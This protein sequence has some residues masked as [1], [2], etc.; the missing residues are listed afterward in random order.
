MNY[1]V[2]VHLKKVLE[3]F[4]HVDVQEE[5]DDEDEAYRTNK[6]DD[7]LAIDSDGELYVAE[8]DGQNATCD[9][10]KGDVPEN[11]TIASQPAAVDFANLP[12]MLNIDDVNVDW[13]EVDKDLEA[14]KKPD[15]DVDT[16]NES[17]DDCF[18]LSEDEARAEKEI[19]NMPA[20]EQ[21]KARKK[22]RR[23]KRLRGKI[24]ELMETDPEW[25]GLQIYLP[26]NMKGWLISKP[27]QV[28]QK[29]YV[30]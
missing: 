17:D 1:A 28:G 29:K 10:G 30:T 22:R 18:E 12:P 11:S 25:K 23:I 15:D 16:D 26:K 4:V 3:H 5:D 19:N 9:K 7:N 8:N 6:G 20:D 13:T 24:E 14:D 2:V 27:E 21:K